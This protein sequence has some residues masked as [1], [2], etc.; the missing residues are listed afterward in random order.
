MKNH[1]FTLIELLVVVLIIGIL[2]A[3]ALPQYQKAV[4]KARFAQ[5]K[6][7]T[8][9]IANAEEV[10]YLANNE[11]SSSF[12]NLDINTPAFTEASIKT[13]SESRTFSWGKCWVSNDEWGPRVGCESDLIGIS[14]YEYLKWG[15]GR[16]KRE[17]RAKNVDISSAQN[18]LCKADTGHRGDAYSSYISYYY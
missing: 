11:Y 4:L 3:V 13:T 12:D 17:C 8:H 5:L 10:Y 14:Y 2:A 9:A 7:M 18:A 6:V 1:A 16:G 15:I